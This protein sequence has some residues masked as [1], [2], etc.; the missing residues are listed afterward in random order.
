MS[1]RRK[2]FWWESAV[3]VI[4]F[5]LLVLTLISREWI[6][7]IFGVDP[8]GGSGAME[9][10]IVLGLAAATVLSVAVA[11]REWRRPGNALVK[12]VRRA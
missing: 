8:D 12:D 10:G 2:L 5:G 11:R 9:W 1:G 7:E 3:A 4:C 6:E